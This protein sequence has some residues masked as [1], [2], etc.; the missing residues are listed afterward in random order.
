MIIGTSG[1]AA[2]AWGNSSRPLIPGTGRPRARENDP[3]FGER[4]GLRL[5]LYRPSMLLELRAFFHTI[6]PCGHAGLTG[7]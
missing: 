4:A 6:D 2:L 3:K 5:D 1:R 7:I